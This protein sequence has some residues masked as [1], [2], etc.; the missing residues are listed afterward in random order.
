[1][2]IKRLT[3]YNFGVYASYNTFIFDNDKTVTL[4]GGRNGR[5]KTTF[6]EAILLA[7]Y[8]S[9]SFAISESK[10]K[11]YGSYL[12]SHIN[13]SD[14][15]NRSYVELEFTM[16]GEDDNNTYIVNR[17]WNADG[18]YIRDAVNVKKNGIEDKFLTQNWTMFIESL[19]PSGL[20]NFFFFDGEKIAELA[21]DET[22]LQMKESIKKLL[23][24][25]VIDTLQKDLMRIERRLNSEQTGD[26]SNEKIEKLRQEKEEK[27]AKRLKL[28]KRIETI[29]K[30]IEIIKR[31][32]GEK[33]KEFDVKGGE[34][35]NQTKSLYSERGLLNGKLEH[36]QSEF[37]DLAASE[38]PLIMVRH[39]IENILKQSGSECEQR[40]MNI[41]IN[42]IN[43]IFSE[44]CTE[45][46]ENSESISQFVDFVKN[47]MSDG[48]A[49]YIYN[50]SDA[51]YMHSE[52]LYN[53]LLKQRQEQYILNKELR[54]NYEKRVNEIDNYLSVDVDEKN[55]NN[56]YQEIETL[57]KHEY[58]IQAQLDALCRE[59]TSMNGEALR[60]TAEFN[61]YVEISLKNMEREDDLDRLKGY[62]H[63]AQ[64]VSERYK[65]ELQKS[66]VTRLAETMTDCYKKLIGKKN[67]IDK[68]EMN[69]ETLDYNYIDK[70]GNEIQK[71]ILS[72]GEKQL[73]VISMLWA[74]GM[75]SGR[76][77][78]VIIDTPL[79]RLDAF[80]RTALIE[81]YFPYASDQTIILSTDSEID[82]TYY[83][84]IEK[85]VGNEFT[86][87]Y[88]EELKQSTVE[89]GYFKGVIG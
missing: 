15:T 18:K 87:V 29:N 83:S 17:S 25:N 84:I 5:G 11:S 53:L 14:G 54:E 69:S 55:I 86:L 12:R 68:I 89:N 50:L 72:A 56:I 44:Y 37:V 33:Q 2:V 24:I 20:S 71:N 66:K 62:V 77:L 9:N 48:E 70:E 80:H 57:K 23:G 74:L 45:K 85:Y 38:L 47:Y 34:I 58:E 22:N 1:M 41:T 6:L 65:I 64:L 4:I 28:D 52:E 43:E 35:A 32:I 60:A 78:P 75:C 59:R 16:N 31:K 3:L 49:D 27:E 21:E 82:K 61:H 7:L 51:A 73:I 10:Y 81:R 13:K 67:L 26:Y 76:K 79:A 36:I 46:N 42:K 40:I 30:E 8:G 88:D 63:M 19:L 39:L